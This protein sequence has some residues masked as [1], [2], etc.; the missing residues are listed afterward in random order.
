MLRLLVLGEIVSVKNFEYDN[1][2][3]H[4]FVE[5]PKGE[6]LMYIIRCEMTNA[7]IQTPFNIT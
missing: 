6:S 4:Y 3:V 1:L 5:L 7:G 2:Y